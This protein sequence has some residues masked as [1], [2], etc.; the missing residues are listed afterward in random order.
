MI[1]YVAFGG[2]VATTWV[3]IIKACML[4]GGASFMA[5]MVLAKFNFSPEAMFQRA[6]EIHPNGTAI[7]QPALWSRTRS[8]P[9]LWA[10]H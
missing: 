4:L 8:R 7:M 3:Q 1:I 2:M 5:F 9:Y 6:T 10:L